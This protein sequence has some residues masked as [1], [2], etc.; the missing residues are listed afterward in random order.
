MNLDEAKVAE[1][2]ERML[3]EVRAT[4]LREMRE[5]RGLT[6]QEVADRMHVSQPRVAAIEKG[7]VPA[8]E[9]GTIERYVSALGG[10]LEIVADFDGDRFALS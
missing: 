10:R 6:Q 8:T 5:R 2:K 7:E 4:R 9:V 1:H 3:A